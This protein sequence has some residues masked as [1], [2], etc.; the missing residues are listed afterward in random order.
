MASMAS[1]C[2]SVT[3]RFLKLL[4]NFR[5]GQHAQIMARHFRRLRNSEQRQ[6]GWRNVLERT[7]GPQSEAAD[8]ASKV[9]GRDGILGHNNKRD[10]IRS[11]RRLRATASGIDHLL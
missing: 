4:L 9:G 6:H 5:R 3:A 1:G 8:V 10:R 7:I 2:S 11:V